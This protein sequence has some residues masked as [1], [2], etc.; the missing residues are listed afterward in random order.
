MVGNK[1]ITEPYAVNNIET[2]KKQDIYR[3]M[4]RSRET[5]DTSLFNKMR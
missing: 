2:I 1:T 4:K 5:R 3:M